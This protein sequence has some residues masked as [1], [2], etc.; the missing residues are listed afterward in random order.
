MSAA[1]PWRRR[2]LRAELESQFG[3]ARFPFRHDRHVPALIVR[4][5]AGDSALDP[6]FRGDTPWPEAVKR[7]L[8]ERGYTL[9]DEALKDSGLG[10]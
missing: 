2:R 5:T 10:D 8:I 6:T 3:S 7:E 9:T 1:A 4:A